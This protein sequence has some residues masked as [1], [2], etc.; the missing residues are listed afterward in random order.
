[1]N[2]TTTR[3]RLVLRVAAAFALG[4]AVYG[5]ASGPWLTVLA[6]LVSVMGAHTAFFIDQLAVEVLDGRMIRITGVLNLGATLV[7]GSMIP[8]LPGQWIKS[9]GP[10]MTVLLVAWVVFFF[11]DASPR[12]RAVL[13]IPLLMITAL[14][15]AIDL[16]VELQGTAIRGLLQG[17]LETFTFRADPINETINQRLVSRLKIL[18]IGEAFMAGGGRLFFGVL[19]GLI[20]HGVTPAIYT[21]PFSPVS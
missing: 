5:F 8:P 17:G 21:R 18:E 14:V 1:M 13:L 12:R 20:P 16:V 7:D 15:C 3:M 9:G 19:A 11:P 2:R 10:S 4:L 6:P